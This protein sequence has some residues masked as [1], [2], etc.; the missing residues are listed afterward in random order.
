MNYHLILIFLL[1][2]GS[3]LSIQIPTFISKLNNNYS[4]TDFA[5]SIYRNLLES[6][7]NINYLNELILI[8]ICLG[9]PPQCFQLIF[10]T[11]SFALWIR[12][13]TISSNINWFNTSFSSSFTSTLNYY[14]IQYIIGNIHGLI[15]MDSIQFN[16]TDSKEILTNITNDFHFLLANEPKINSN[17]TGIFGF[18]RN[19]D[20]KI[21]GV[22]SDTVYEGNHF[23]IINYLQKNKIINETIFAYKYVSN[24][25]GIL[26]LGEK[27]V[28][29]NLTYPKCFYSEI[30]DD[31]KI[32]KR[33]E[34]FLN[35]YYWTCKIYDLKYENETK[36]KDFEHTN[37]FYQVLFDTG[38]SVIVIPKL[39]YNQIINDY[40][41]SSNNQCY[42]KPK[43]L[44]LYCNQSFNIKN[45]PKYKINLF[46]FTLELIPQDL[47][48][49]I[50]N[51]TESMY[52]FQFLS[53]NDDNFIIGSNVMKRYHFI[54]DLKEG[55]VGAIINED[56]NQ[57]E[58]II[59]PHFYE[60]FTK[61]Y[62]FKIVF[63]RKIVL[64]FI[65]S[66]IIICGLI[67]VNRNKNLIIQLNKKY[68]ENNIILIEQK[69]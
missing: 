37:H 14:D 53:Q 45:L 36:V 58:G 18:G 50:Y 57:L 16:K 4:N 12:E 63:S 43:I 48:K 20:R 30:K 28:L 47:L 11:G 27:G 34:Y 5:Q 15:A 56:F 66:I 25:K 9:T 1:F 22:D 39:F 40:L 49:L 46:N 26:Y 44:A 7:I 54:F 33:N 29:P 67:L 61:I 62:N 31:Y 17:I 52:L 68:K 10:D 41:N 13:K 69:E 38:A 65:I 35:K 6:I 42:T 24:E 60:T 59:L 23:S 51:N 8:P 32:I 55:S 19:Y 3:V 64:L 21:K 2:F